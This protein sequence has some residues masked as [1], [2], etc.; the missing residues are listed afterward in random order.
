[1][2]VATDVDAVLRL[3][4]A[5]RLVEAAEIYKAVHFVLLQ[6]KIRSPRGDWASI[7][8][9]AHSRLLVERFAAVR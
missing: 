1:M 2:A 6:K 7:I 3:H 4:Q 8:D 9:R 5:G